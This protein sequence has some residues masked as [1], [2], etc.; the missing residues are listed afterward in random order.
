MLSSLLLCNISWKASSLPLSRM[1]G[2]EIRGKY[3][4][5]F[6]GDA[7]GDDTPLHVRE[8]PTQLHPEGVI[9]GG[10]SG[11]HA[12]WALQCVTQVIHLQVKDT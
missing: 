3:G 1:G 11:F 10:V 9:R 8:Q 6:D 4:G 5:D 7:G 2:K 12:A